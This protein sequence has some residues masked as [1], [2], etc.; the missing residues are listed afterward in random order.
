MCSVEKT[1]I[2]DIRLTKELAEEILVE[3]KSYQTIIYNQDKRIA[4][5]EMQNKLIATIGTILFGALISY[6]VAVV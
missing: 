3:F 2:T 1:C 4:L 5:L 6:L